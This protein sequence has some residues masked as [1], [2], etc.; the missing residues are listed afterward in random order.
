M[1][2][3]TSNFYVIYGDGYPIYV[4]FTIRNVNKRFKEHLNQKD[5]SIFDNIAVDKVSSIVH[6]VDYSDLESI[7]RYSKEV[8]ARESKLIEEYGTKDSTYQKAV[9]GGSV[10]ATIIHLS[11]TYKTLNSQ[12]GVSVEDMENLYDTSRTNLGK[13]KQYVGN[14][15]SHEDSQL[16]GYIVKTYNLEKSV[17]FDYIHRTVPSKVQ[18]LRHYVKHTNDKHFTVISGYIGVTVG[19]NEAK[20]KSYISSTM[21]SEKVV[22]KNYIG[23]TATK[24]KLV[25]KAYIKNT[26]D[27]RK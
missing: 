5:F 21:T 2:T 24:E 6:E 4:G 16:R 7:Y 9:G 8:S 23:G 22:I 19:T 25:L 17:L 12:L 3:I 26:M 13:L 27:K 11:K 18:E 10:W 15:L 14:T 20:L 1:K